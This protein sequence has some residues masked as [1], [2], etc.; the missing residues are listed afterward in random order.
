MN[1]YDFTDVLSFRAAPFF[2]GVNDFEFDN[3]TGVLEAHRANLTL[4]SGAS[5]AG[6]FECT[7]P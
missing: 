2:D 5:A 4:P 7:H 1:V 3:V 6:Y